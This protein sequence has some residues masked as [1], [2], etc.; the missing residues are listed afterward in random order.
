MKKYSIRH[1]DPV[2]IEGRWI[3]WWLS[4]PSQPFCV[5]FETFKQAID[6]FEHFRKTGWHSLDAYVPRAWRN[7]YI[8]GLY[9]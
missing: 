6:G 3:A 9:R 4:A 1:F 7:S 2:Q 5:G 8:Q